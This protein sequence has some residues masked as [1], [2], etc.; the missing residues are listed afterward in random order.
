MTPRSE[1]VRLALPKGRMQAK[2]LELLTE[3]GVPVR[4][5]ERDYRPSIGLDGFVCKLLKPRNIVEMLQVGTRDVGLAGADWV[6]EIG[7]GL[8][9]LLDT[10]LDQVR[11]VA[12]APEATIDLSDAGRE[13]PI[14]VATEYERLTKA[15]IERRGLRADVL[16]VHGATE[17]FPPDDADCIVDNT[18]SGATLR[19]NGLTIIDELMRSSTR[20]YA[21]ER[22]LDDPVKRERIEGFVLLLGAVV[23]ARRRVMLE[24]NVPARSL[25]AVVDMLPCMREPTVASLHGEQGYAVRAAV[26]REAIAALIPQLK[27]A[28]GSD[29]V[30]SQPAQIIP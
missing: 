20:V 30:V 17:V 5:G 21:S 15:W 9:E 1:L 6:S 16:R 27:T 22:A 14:L 18:A 3:A 8:V 24:L 26:P 4:L 28:G 25:D 11:V 10:R 13:Q 29:L 23:E 2:A 12:A 19:A 7:A